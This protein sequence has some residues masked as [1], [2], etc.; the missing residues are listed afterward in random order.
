MEMSVEEIE[1]GAT[2]AALRGR[3]D[4]VGTGLIELKFSAIAGS[5]RALIVDLSEVSFLASMGIRLL[6]IGAKA[7]GSKGGKMVV[8]SPS[9]NLAT[10]LKTAGIDAIIPI[11][12]ERAAA[13]A[14]VTA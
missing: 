1:G 2:R 10:V 5:R 13:V 12:Y 8:L 4:V 3:L 6:V 9:E 14:A 11:F 7:V